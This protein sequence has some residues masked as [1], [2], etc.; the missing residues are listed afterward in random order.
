MLA[1][2]NVDADAPAGGVYVMP[3]LFGDVLRD[4]VLADEDVF[5]QVLL[6]MIFEDEADA[7]ALANGTPYG[8]EARVWMRNTWRSIR[9]ERTVCCGQVFVNGYS[10]GD[11]IELPFGGVKKSGRG[12]E[13][14]LVALFVF[15]A[16]KTIVLYHG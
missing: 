9:F 7:I 2:G 3:T 11:G 1:K 4:R 8:L 10:A 12:R 15:R 5:G 14:G 13:K 16:S 6:L